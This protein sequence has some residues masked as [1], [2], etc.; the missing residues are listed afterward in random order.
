MGIGKFNRRPIFYNGYYTTDAG[1]GTTFIET[2]RWE[3]WAQ[4]ED[5]SSGNT[6]AQS[7]EMMTEEYRVKVRFDGKF[8]SQTWMI[9][10]GQV[11]KCVSMSVESE[12]Y[13]HFLNFRF[14]KTNTWLDLS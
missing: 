8:N 13:K 10:E 11:C 2:E 12:G 4:I 9:Y 7:Q 6:T 1:S 3:W 14:S 5:G